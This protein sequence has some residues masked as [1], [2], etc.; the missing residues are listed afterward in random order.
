MN[1]KSRGF[2][3]VLAALI[4]ALSFELTYLH[5][6][7]TPLP[8]AIAKKELFVSLIGLPDLALANDAAFVRHRSLSS[9]FDLYRDGENLP[10]YFPTASIYWHSTRINQTPSRVR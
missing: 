8:E 2:I 10:I 3:K 7:Q 4:V 5:H 1:T 9:I 6:T